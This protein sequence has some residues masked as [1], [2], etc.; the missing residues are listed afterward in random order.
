MK[1]TIVGY[2]IALLLAVS[3]A[4]AADKAPR[5]VVSGPIIVAFFSPNS[6]AHD[7]DA[8]EA[9]ADF[10]LYAS[11]VRSPLE[12]RGIE[13]RQVSAREFTI[14]DGKTERAF[15]PTSTQVG[16][17]LVAPGRTPRVEYGVLTDTDLLQIANEYFG[18]HSH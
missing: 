12:Q 18:T 2:L 16:Y 3:P 5:I 10:Q 8:N 6:D 1:T 9:L 14:V 4:T 13:F 15:K 7:A 11:Q 17:Y